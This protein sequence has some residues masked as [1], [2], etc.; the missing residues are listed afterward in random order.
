MLLRSSRINNVNIDKY[1]KAKIV[2][3]SEDED[4]SDLEDVNIDKSKL[5]I[6]DQVKLLKKLFC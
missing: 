1:I 5:L 3:E 4:D 2:S 6:E